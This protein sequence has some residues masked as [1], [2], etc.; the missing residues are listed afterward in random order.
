MLPSVVT[1]LFSHFFR[2]DDGIVLMP[3]SGQNYFWS[4]CD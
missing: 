2:Q 1:L 3:F 4:E